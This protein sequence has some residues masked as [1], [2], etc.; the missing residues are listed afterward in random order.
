MQTLHVKTPIILLLSRDIIFLIFVVIGF[1]GVRLKK[2]QFIC[3]KYY[4]RVIKGII[5]FY[6]IYFVCIIP[7]FFCMKYRDIVQYDIR[8]LVFYSLIIFLIPIIFTN[9]K[10][11]DNFFKYLLKLSL[12]FCVVVLIKRLCGWNISWSGRAVGG[13][14]DANNFGVFMTL[15]M[16]VIMSNWKNLN[17]YKYL[18]II[19]LFFALVLTSSVS[20]FMFFIVGAVFICFF[21]LKNKWLKI[22]ASFIVILLLI[23]GIVFVDSIFKMKEQKVNFKNSVQ[24]EY[25]TDIYLTDKINRMTQGGFKKVFCF[26]KDSNYQKKRTL[27]SLD[28]RVRQFSNFVFNNKAEV[29]KLAYKTYDGQYFNLY[30]NAGIGSIILFLVLFIY[31][32]YTALSLWYRD[33]NKNALVIGSFIIALISVGWLS[34]AFL[35]RYP[36]NFISYLLLCIVFMYKDLYYRKNYKEKT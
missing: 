4:S 21:M 22:G 17:I 33:N 7:H 16:F 27:D 28:S 19:L 32:G 23:Y 1:I 24:R 18:N 5:L 13:M 10:Q 31:G 25:S 20:A 26:Y 12:F 30:Y 9:K 6:L 35:G 8:G 14:N 36:I 15:P 11:I 2:L 34:T 3:G 29:D